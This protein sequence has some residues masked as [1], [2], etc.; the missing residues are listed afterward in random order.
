MTR[1][2]SAQNVAA[3]A[4]N[5]RSRSTL[6][7]EARGYYARYDETSRQRVVRDERAARAA[8]SSTSATA[9]PTLRCA[10]RSAD[11]S[12]CRAASSGRGTTTAATTDSAT[13]AGHTAD[14]S[15]FWIQ[16]QV[17]LAES[18]HRDRRPALRQPLDLRRRV[19][20]EARRQR[21]CDRRSAPARLVRPRLPR[22]RSR[23]ALLPL[24][25]SDQP[26]SGDRQPVAPARA[27]GLGAGRRRLL[28]ATSRARRRQPVPQRRRRSD[29]VG[30]PRVHRE[31]GAA[32]GDHGG[33][34]H[35]P[36]VPAAAPSAALP[37]QEPDRRAYAGRRGRRRRGARRPASAS[38]ARLHLA[39][40]A[41]IASRVWR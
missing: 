33:R 1:D 27:I 2:D 18:R 35:R 26:L 11:Y 8:A 31:P 6:A 14:T 23:S 32:A 20:A 5:G 36:V 30:E 29:R 25:Q 13:I 4:R 21:P 7:L 12:W 22:A 41:R 19:V 40:S 38:S 3:Q 15:V 24:P 16:D 10:G 34:R 39:A 28:V 9:A 37:L 17:S